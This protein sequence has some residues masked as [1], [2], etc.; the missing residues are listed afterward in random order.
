MQINILPL[1]EYGSIVP[2][3]CLVGRLTTY[4]LVYIYIYVINITNSE[5]LNI[6]IQN[7]KIK[8]KT[9]QLRFLISAAQLCTFARNTSIY[10]CLVC[11]LSIS[12]AQLY[13][14]TK[15]IYCCLVCRLYKWHNRSSAV[16]TRPAQTLGCRLLESC[17]ILYN[18]YI[19][20]SSGFFIACDGLCV[21][22]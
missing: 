10:C 2:S 13:V 7:K 11:R 4:V 3:C 22:W 12:S 5:L 18:P 17:D 16:L 6:H 19:I 8:N 20:Q 21:C 1:C 9:S 15:Y 14:R